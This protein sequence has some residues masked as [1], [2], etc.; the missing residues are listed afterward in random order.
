MDQSIPAHEVGEALRPFLADK[1]KTVGLRVATPLAEGT[2]SIGV[3][4]LGLSEGLGQCVVCSVR[5]DFP[6]DIEALVLQVATNQAA[7]ALQEVG[8][9]GRQRRSA[10][11]P[12]RRVVE[13]TQELTAANE[14][15]QREAM[16]RARSEEALA[17]TEDRLRRMAD[18]IPEVIWIN[19]H[20]S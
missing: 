7:M 14:A 17:E 16:E 19:P 10:E 11:E 13:R 18:C 12:E 2:V 3:F 1:A 6:T 15:L 4:P 8:N 5:T 20:N 9:I